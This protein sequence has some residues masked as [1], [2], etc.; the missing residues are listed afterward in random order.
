MRAVNSA[1]ETPAL[2]RVHHMPAKNT[3]EFIIPSKLI[4]I[5][6][7]CFVFIAE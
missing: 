2:P 7:N 3:G 4:F 1:A 6:F 5:T